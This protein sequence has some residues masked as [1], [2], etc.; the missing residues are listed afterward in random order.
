MSMSHS[1]FNHRI[2]HPKVVL[3]SRAE[4][5]NHDLCIKGFANAAGV[6]DIWNGTRVR[7][8]ENGPELI[9]FDQDEASFHYAI[10]QTLSA[11][12]QLHL[13]NARIPETIESLRAWLRVQYGP[14]TS[15]DNTKL[16][17]KKIRTVQLSGYD[18]FSLYRQAKEELFTEYLEAGGALDEAKRKEFI[19]NGTG[20]LYPIETKTFKAL[21]NLRSMDE[22]ISDFEELE[23]ATQLEKIEA[24]GKKTSE[25]FQTRT[26]FACFC[27]LNREHGIRECPFRKGNGSW[28]LHCYTNKHWSKDCPKPTELKALTFDRENGGDSEDDCEAKYAYNFICDDMIASDDELAFDSDLEHEIGANVSDIH[29][30]F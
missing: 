30:R 4:Y 28:C 18:S 5:L 17:E 14:V 11:K 2:P 12:V 26:N 29:D 22:I 1:K 15:V 23:I 20:C 27:C 9:G 21:G 13:L 10:V 16:I 19:L 3:K 24:N 8:V 7:P 25:T 6:S